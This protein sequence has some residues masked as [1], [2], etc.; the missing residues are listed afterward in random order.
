MDDGEIGAG[1]V[2]CQI[3]RGDQALL[4]VAAADALHVFAAVVG[5]RRVGRR[6]RDK[7]QPPNCVLSPRGTVI[8]RKLGLVSGKKRGIFAKSGFALCKVT[9]H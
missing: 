5:Q 4:V 1:V 8:L 9:Y 2:V 7:C 6:R 3:M